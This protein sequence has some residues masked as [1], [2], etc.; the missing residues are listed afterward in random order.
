[1]KNKA[2]IVLCAVSISLSLAALCIAYFRCE[3]LTMDWMGVLVGVLSFL[4]TL[5]LGWQIYTLIDIR[6][7]Q[8][9]MKEKDMKIYKRSELNLAE[10]HMALWAFYQTCMTEGNLAENSHYGFVQSGISSIVHFSRYGDYAKAD[11]IASTL[12]HSL[13]K[14]KIQEHS[15][16]F[17]DTSLKALV[18]G[19]ENPNKIPMFQ[20]L[21]EALYKVR[22]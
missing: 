7:I 18:S 19:V 9:E 14:L 13:P 5:L 8:Q 17:F 1:M 6:K 3:P 10:A 15:D 4:V 16:E 12:V 2:V 21:L 20:E 22:G 11:S